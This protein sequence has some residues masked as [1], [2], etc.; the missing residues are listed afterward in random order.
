MEGKK[1]I[2]VKDLIEGYGEQYVEKN[3]EEQKKKIIKSLFSFLDRRICG[4]YPED[5]ILLCGSANDRRGL[6]FSLID[7]ICIEDGKKV[8]LFPGES[9]VKCVERLVLLKTD[10]LLGEDLDAIKIIKSAPLYIADSTA[11]VDD[12]CA[13]SDELCASGKEQQDLDLIIIDSIE[14]SVFHRDSIHIIDKLKKYAN[15]YQC[16]ILFMTESDILLDN[17]LIEKADVVMEVVT[18]DKFVK[19]NAALKIYKSNHGIRFEMLHEED[20]NKFCELEE[21]VS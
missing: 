18:R 3:S 13:L 21:H 5:I 1:L 4:F 16:V 9:A 17:M 12:I 20:K 14:L 6:A 2:V 8:I 11:N 15:K 7:N 10:K 19:G